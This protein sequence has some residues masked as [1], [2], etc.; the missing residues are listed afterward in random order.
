MTN[1]WFPTIAHVVLGD[2]A[3]AAPTISTI[4]L[5]G[6]R[7]CVQ[8]ALIPDTSANRNVRYRRDKDCKVHNE[9]ISSGRI[10]FVR[11]TKIK[12]T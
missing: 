2:K 6:R 11:G 1:T 12:T 7:A 4:L 9:T 5:A 8:P 3:H 10:L